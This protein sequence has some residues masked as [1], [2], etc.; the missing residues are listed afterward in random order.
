MALFHIKHLIPIY[1]MTYF[2]VITFQE[3]PQVNLM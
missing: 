1:M 3:Q 2:I